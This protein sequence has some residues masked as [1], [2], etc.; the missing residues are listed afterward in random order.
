MDILFE[1]DCGEV[2]LREFKLEDAEAISAIAAQPEVKEFL[3][4]WDSTPEHRQQVMIK[5]E[6]PSN[7]GFL[8]AVPDIGGLSKYH[9]FLNL[10][11]IHKKSG[12]VIG[13]VSSG[14][15]KELPAPNREVAYAISGEYRNKGYTTMAVSGMI[16]FLFRETNLMLLNAIALPHNIASNKV[17]QKCGFHRVED[18]VIEGRVH[19]HYI[20]RREQWGQAQG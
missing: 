1:I 12:R 6:I 18:A 10:S 3:P 15:K 7:K 9:S 19:H 14:I 4:E 20:M 13:F 17:I 11:M 16:D 2:M 8:A 5:Y